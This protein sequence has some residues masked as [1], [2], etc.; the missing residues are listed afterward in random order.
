VETGLL[1]A[2][3]F[4]KFF[5][6]EVNAVRASTASTPVFDVP[7]RETL[8][9]EQWSSVIS[10]EVERLISSALN[11][12]SRLNPAPTWLV[13]DMGNLLAPFI[14]LLFDKSLSS[15]CFPAGKLQFFH[16]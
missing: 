1:S 8:T 9:L 7:F 12:T 16:C 11:K 13:K 10:D 3:D 15:G 14:A 6:D 4:A 5:Q 2:D